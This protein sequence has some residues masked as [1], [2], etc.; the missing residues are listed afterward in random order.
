MMGMA[1]DKNDVV[2]TVEDDS[3]ATN[4]VAT[5]HFDEFGNP[6]QSGFLEGGDAEYGWLGGKKRRTQLPSGVIQMGRRSYVPAV[7]RFISTDPIAGGSANAYDYANADP[8]NGLDLTG[9][10]ACSIETAPS[11]YKVILDGPNSA[12]AEYTIGFTAHWTRNATHR[13]MS[14]AVVGG[15]IRQPVPGVPI[16]VHRHGS[17]T[18]CPRLTCTHSVRGSVHVLAPC[19]TSA[20]GYI[21]AVAT[22]SWTPRGHG[23]HGRRGSVSSHQKFRI[24]VGHACD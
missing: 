5:Q 16:H 20:N 7:G 6:M 18:D 8:I 22:I 24:R 23:R 13:S 2:S 15:F 4:V 10:A 9:Q 12:T 14:V 1:V 19:D 17:S 11:G 3:E 21:E